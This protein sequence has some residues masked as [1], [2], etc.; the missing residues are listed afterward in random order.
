MLM[1]VLKV[2]VAAARAML[3][4]WG[5]PVVY[6]APFQ[7]TCLLVKLSAV[8]ASETCHGSTPLGSLLD[9]TM[10]EVTLGS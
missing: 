9:F 6:F 4:H 8:G 10:L 3:R 1:K 5:N 2:I 7:S